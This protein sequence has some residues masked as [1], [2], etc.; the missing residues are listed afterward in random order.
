M[1]QWIWLWRYLLKAVI[2][3][4]PIYT[5]SGI[6][7]YDVLFLMFWGNHIIFHNGCINSTFL[8]VLQRTSLPLHPC[9]YLLF[10]L[11]IF[12]FLVF[13]ITATGV[14]WYIIVG[15]ICISLVI[16]NFDCLFVCWLFKYLWENVHS[17]T[18]SIFNW[19]ILLFC[20]ELCEFSCILK[21]TR[22]RYEICK[23]FLLIHMLPFLSLIIS[24]AL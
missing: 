11:S 1:L 5:Q 14:K 15:L 23:Y 3:F 13:F 22:I 17:D 18:L 7:R 8:P 24:F 9:Q 6:S 21:L 4:L 16:S 2:S 12:L 19:I 20:F 10:L